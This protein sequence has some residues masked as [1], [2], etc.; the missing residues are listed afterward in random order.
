MA[1][2]TIATATHPATLS[3]FATTPGIGF[4]PKE[5]DYVRAS[6]TYNGLLPIQEQ[7]TLQGTHTEHIKALIAI[8]KKH[9]MDLYFGIHS[10]H[11]HGS[12]PDK[13]I[14]LET[15]LEL[16]GGNMGGSFKWNRATPI[17]DQLLAQQTHATLIKVEGT[18][19]V[20]VEFAPGPPPIPADSIPGKFVVDM[21]GYLRDHG[22]TDL[23]AIQ[24]GNFDGAGRTSELEVDWPIT[25]EDVEQLTVVLPFDR[26]VK[27][28]STPVPT[29]WNARGIAGPDAGSDADPPA[30]EHWNKSTKP[31]GAVTH[32]VHYDSIEPLSPD[33]LVAGLVRL[34][35]L[36]AN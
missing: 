29:G 9:N 20:P 1:T 13:T 6:E 18:G 21:V 4:T 22:L 23:I 28:H 33:N 12:I 24:F 8:I 32:K 27:E 36:K 25:G 14:R 16:P 2:A 5:S 10:L 11:R 19:L 31:G 17:T 3:G 35:Y 15:D 30:G 34:G 7:A 26:M